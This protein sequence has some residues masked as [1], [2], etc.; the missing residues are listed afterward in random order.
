MAAGLHQRS[1][2]IA[3]LQIDRRSPLEQ[4]LHYA[5]RAKSARQH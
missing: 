2:I 1:F 3:G 4:Q 5:L